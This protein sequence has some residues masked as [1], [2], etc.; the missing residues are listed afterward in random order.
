MAFDTSLLRTTG[1]TWKQPAAGAISPGATYPTNQFVPAQPTQ[2]PGI[3]AAPTSQ[4]TNNQQ[5]TTPVYDPVAEAAAAEAKAKA[6]NQRITQNNF[7]A[8]YS[9]M[10]AGQDSTLDKWGIGYGAGHRSLYNLILGGQEAIDTLGAKNELNLK[11]GTQGVLGMVGRGTKSAGVM[12]GNRNAGSSSATDRIAKAYA[13]MG[14][15]EMG[16]IGNQY[17]MEN[18]DINTQQ[19]ALGRQEEEGF[20]NLNE[21]KQIMLN[22]IIADTRTKVNALKT[23]M[24]N[25]DLPTQIN[26]QAEIDSVTAEGVAKAKTVEDVWKPK[27]TGINARNREGNMTKAEEMM[28]AGMDLGKDAF[29]YTSE[30]PVDWQG[31]LPAGSNLPLYTIPTKRKV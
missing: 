29:N 28:T 3:L 25:A 19:T 27:I 23:M 5:N 20:A 15:T 30:A 1:S 26:L 16:N 12:L 22:E 8:G 4:P 2:G 14:Q 9:E 18:L 6:E 17:A 31:P 7:N 24:L 11:R 10:N 13:N 21:G